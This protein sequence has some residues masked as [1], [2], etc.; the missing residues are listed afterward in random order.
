MPKAVLN[1]RIYLDNTP[2]LEKKL[3]AELVYK[4]P[5]Y[6]PELPPKVLTNVRII[7]DKVISIPSG[8]VDLIPD[9]YDII[10]HRVEV[11][12][13]MPEFPFQLR[14]SQQEVYDGVDSSCFINAFTSWGKTFTG[15]AIASKLGQ[16][17]FVLVHTKVLMDQWSK[18]VEKLFGFTPSI[19]GGG[20]KEFHAPITIGNIQSVTRA[21]KQLLAK[22]FGTLIIDECHHCPATSFSKFLDVNHAKYKIGLSA[23]D[24]RKD[25]THVMFPDF[26]GI[27]K[28]EPPPENFIEPEIHVINLPITFPD[29]PDPWHSKITH[30][31]NR[32]DYRKF[33]QV[34]ITKY[35]ADGH[36]V[37]ALYN[38][39]S[40][41]KEM[42]M[43]T[44]P[45]SVLITGE[46]KSQAEREQLLDYIR[47]GECSTVHGSQ[48]LFAEGF[49]E[50]I[51]SALLLGTPTNNEPLLE[52]L[53]GRVI[54]KSPGKRQ[55]VVIDIRMKGKTIE[56]QQRARDGYYLRKGYKVIHF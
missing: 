46:I 30:L 52:Q 40:L 27:K 25:G 17:T 6:R 9:D 1:N 29:G 45:D 37:L 33:L 53:I 2:E 42:H 12:V 43:L 24:K 26:F 14:P 48:N 35:A 47:R 54:R 13:E 44:H 50:N 23:S 10:D 32:E 15:L 31:V 49:S 56:K 18:E 7:N 21:P 20:K 36:K 19:Y 55:P 41:A 22:E 16:K 39:V 3:L 38:R 51:L 28:F 34:I 4:I 5:Q 11:P 8:R